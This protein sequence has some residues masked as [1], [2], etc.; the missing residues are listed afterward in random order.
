MVSVDA[1]AF[2][3]A[4]V[5]VQTR[6]DSSCGSAIFPGGNRQVSLE[7]APPIST[8]YR[9]N[10]VCHVCPFARFISHRPS[11]F[12]FRFPT[13]QLKLAYGNRACQNANASSMRPSAPS[14]RAEER[15]PSHQR[16]NPEKP[17]FQW[18][19]IEIE[20]HGESFH[21]ENEV[22]GCRLSNELDRM[23]S[24]L[25]DTLPRRTK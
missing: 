16:S 11:S 9:G 2:G 10:Y 19:E 20:L 5:S 8:A 25:F 13:F 17:S 18:R 7:V 24:R 3:A 23:L 21:W 22:I 6:E 1:C 14:I 4:T 15:T 12:T